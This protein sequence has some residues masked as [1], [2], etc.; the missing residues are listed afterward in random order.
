MFW[1]VLAVKIN[2]KQ[3]FEIPHGIPLFFR[4]SLRR[5]FLESCGCED[6]LKKLKR[7]HG[8][9][10]CFPLSQ[11]RRVEGSGCDN[12]RTK[13]LVGF[14]KVLAVKRNPPKGLKRNMVYS[15]FFVPHS[16]V[17]VWKSLVVKINSQKKLKTPH[18]FPPFLLYLFQL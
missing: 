6:Q 11:R 8:F 2:S 3:K 1:K 17:G 13:K 9:V 14:C 18:G 4:L 5:R 15:V 16:G 10:F 12:Q 7:L